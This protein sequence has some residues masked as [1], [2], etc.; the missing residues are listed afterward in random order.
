MPQKLIQAVNNMT[1]S[2]SYLNTAY[3][4]KFG[5]KHYGFDCYGTNT[6]V[7]AQGYGVVLS[8]G[9][10]SCYGNFAV[11]LYLDVENAGDIVANYFHFASVGVSNGQIINKDT[12]LG[13]MGKTGTYATGVHLHT[14]MRKYELGQERMLSPFSTPS[15][16]KDLQAGWFDPLSVI[17]CKTN[18]PDNQTYKTTGDAYIN[19]NN[20]TI[21]TLS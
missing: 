19:S 8:T 5:F 12:K 16:A 3:E 17:Y 2:A 11:I 13:V 10:D 21:K 18:G 14:E 4:K 6:T 9:N 20:K 15:F 1:V 7:Y